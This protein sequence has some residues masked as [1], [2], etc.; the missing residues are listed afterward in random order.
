MR[1]THVDDSKEEIMKTSLTT[2]QKRNAI[3]V[4]VLGAILTAMVVILQMLGQFI[5][6][7]PFVISLV[8]LPIVI[9]AATCGP[10]VSTWLGF[11]FG[12]IV[13]MTD[14][15]LFLA[16]NVPGTVITVLIKGTACG[17]A[18]GLVY[19]FFEKYNRYLAVVAAAVVCPIVNTGL[20]LLGCSVFFMD[21]MNTWGAEAGFT[22][23]F[24]YM[25]LVLVGG[26]FLF[27]LATNIILSP[28]IVRILELTKMTS[29]K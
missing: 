13:L 5:R 3:R 12:V 10:K 22:N 8:L 21:T 25:I 19:R 20:F 16:I 28:A 18:A 2:A 14:A 26:N 29:R 24:A 6:F 4:T 23:T 9:G 11:I 27:E 17:L 1:C 7:G 15:A